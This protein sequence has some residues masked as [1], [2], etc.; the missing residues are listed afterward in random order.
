MLASMGG[1]DTR[2]RTMADRAFAAGASDPGSSRGWRRLAAPALAAAAV[3]LLTVSLGPRFGLEFP[4]AKAV[5]YSASA[6]RSDVTLA[7]GS[8]V[9]LD[10]QSSIKVRLAARKRLVE[11]VAGR[12]FFE[13]A[14]D[15]SRPFTVSAGSE[16]ITALGTRFQVDR[17]DQFVLVTLDE[18]SI[19]VTD[20]AADGGERRD[21]LTP[22][23]QL[24]VAL[25]GSRSLRQVDSQVATSWSQGRLVF[26]ATPLAE[27][28]DEFN[29][30]SSRKLRLG[31]ASLAQM[32]VS[33]SFIPGDNALAVSALAAVLPVKAVDTGGEIVLFPSNNPEPEAHSGSNG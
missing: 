21:V 33:G 13:V 31:D 30:Y 23:Q 2:L 20:T 32:Q 12:A 18:G 26:H 5:Y 28:L 11:L 25:D 10:A 17:H 27:V 16:R 6:Q 3:A 15:A 14:H 24:K 29:R 19:A 8:L 22:G 9:H 1:A 4:P 7:D